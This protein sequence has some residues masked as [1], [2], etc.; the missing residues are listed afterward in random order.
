[1]GL[2]QLRFHI[3]A[4]SKQPVA[5]SRLKGMI[6]N[7]IH[8]RVC[9]EITYLFPDLNGAAIEVW[10]WI[11][12]FITCMICNY[13]HYIVCDEITY[14]FPKFNGAAIEVWEWISNFTTHITRLVITY[15]WWDLS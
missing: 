15:L 4:A 8:Y 6:S 3:A 12:N 1:M 11:S 2:T 10:E 7:Y 13:I 14:P 9:D 5:A